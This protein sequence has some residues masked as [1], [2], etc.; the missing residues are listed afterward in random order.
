MQKLLR[1]LLVGVALVVLGGWL[2]VWMTGPKHHITRESIFRIKEGMTQHE[3]EEI[4]GAPPGD[5]SPGDSVVAYLEPPGRLSGNQVA[6][7]AF[8]KKAVWVGDEAAVRVW[9]N[10]NDKAARCDYGFVVRP[11]ISLLDKVRRWLGL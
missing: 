4:L 9:F 10:N 2:T 1:L 8:A 7:I 11:Q 5:Y 3:I 6:A